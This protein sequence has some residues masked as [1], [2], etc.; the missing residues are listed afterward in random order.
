MKK[1]STQDKVYIALAV[2]IVLFTFFVL[3][4]S[5][6]ERQ[7][8]RNNKEYAYA[9]ITDFRRGTRGS[10]RLEYKFFVG[11]RR[12]NGSGVHHPEIDMVSVGD[13]IVIVFDRKNPENNAT[14]RDLENSIF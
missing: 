3:R 10:H 8:L 5:Y 1:I 11:E 12:Y 9:V 2:L 6:I 13:T 14:L 4:N 7:S